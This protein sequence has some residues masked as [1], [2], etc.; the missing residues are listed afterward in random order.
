MIRSTRD[1]TECKCKT[2]GII[3]L[4]GQT[5]NG[6]RCC[7]NPRPMIIGMRT[8]VD[9]EKTNDEEKAEV[10]ADMRK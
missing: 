2:C 6:Q 3:H 1:V 7:N 5:F 9:Y 10:L 4:L 8:V